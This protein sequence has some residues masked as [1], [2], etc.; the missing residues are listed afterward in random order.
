MSTIKRVIRS[1]RRS[2]YKNEYEEL[3][4]RISKRDRRKYQARRDRNR[5]NKVRKCGKE[6]DTAAESESEQWREKD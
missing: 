4:S 3:R 1:G 2:E 5:R 6:Q